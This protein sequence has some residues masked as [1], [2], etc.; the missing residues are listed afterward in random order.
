M[1][2]PPGTLVCTTVPNELVRME[3]SSTKLQDQENTFLKLGTALHPV[4]QLKVFLARQMNKTG[5][6]FKYRFNLFTSAK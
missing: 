5:D 6:F 1:S 2:C 3:V 4:F